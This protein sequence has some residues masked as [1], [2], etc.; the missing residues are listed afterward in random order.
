MRLSGQLQ[1]SL[2]LL[3]FLWKDFARTIVFVVSCL[4]VFV[5]L[6]GF[7]LWRVFVRVK[8]FHKNKKNLARSCRENL[9]YYST[10][11]YPYRPAYQEFV[12][13]KYMS[14]VFSLSLSLSFLS[15]NFFSFYIYLIIIIIV[16]IIFYVYLSSTCRDLVEKRLRFP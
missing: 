1:A 7:S 9:K 12:C 8:S 15:F 4:L 3:F 11:V 10:D 14:I 2:L 6:V 5:L 16:I 13:L